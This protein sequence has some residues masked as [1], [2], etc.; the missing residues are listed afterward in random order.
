MYITE[1]L[2]RKV[3]ARAAQEGV[4]MAEWVHDALEEALLVD[5]KGDKSGR[6]T[7]QE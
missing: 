4:T 6:M 2:R 5:T 3:K 7:G 1:E